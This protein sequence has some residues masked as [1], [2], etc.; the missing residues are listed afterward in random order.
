[1]KNPGSQW[2][3]K[4]YVDDNM[5]NEFLPLPII[6]WHRQFL[7]STETYGKDLLDIGCGTGR[8]LYEARNLGYRVSGID[9]NS[10]SIRIAK[11]RFGLNEVERLSVDA[12]SAKYP[13]KKF[14]VI[15]FF[16]V[17]EHMEDPNKFISQVKTMLKPGGTIAL[18]VPNRERVLDSL[19]E[20]DYPPHH[21]TRWSKKALRIF[22]EKNGFEVRTLKVKEFTV[23]DVSLVM[24]HKLVGKAKR[25][26]TK[27][28]ATAA[29]ENRSAPFIL[30]NY[31]L[32]KK[33]KDYAMRGALLP[34]IPALKVLKLN[35]W[36]IFC[37]ARMK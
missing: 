24:T 36:T 31:Q 18:S 7:E 2:Y 21:L 1:M 23:D 37:T 4:G 25:K 3:E 12:L 11:K 34:L 14:D 26:L 13:E 6:W 29:S 5:M 17:L 33:L 10:E 16:E 9:F 15:S 20:G 30:R 8:F 28:V 22:L 19:G 27:G 35:G 32:I